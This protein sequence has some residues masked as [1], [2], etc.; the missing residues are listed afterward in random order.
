M[1]ISCFP[2]IIKQVQTDYPIAMDGYLRRSQEELHHL[3]ASSRPQCSWAHPMRYIGN[4]NL[5]YRQLCSLSLS[6]EWKSK[7]IHH[8]LYI[9]RITLSAPK[10]KKETHTQWHKDDPIVKESEWAIIVRMSWWHAIAVFGSPTIFW[11]KFWTCDSLV[12]STFL[13]HAQKHTHTNIYR[14]TNIRVW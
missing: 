11:T 3:C 1:V 5:K 2:N 14:Q 9:Y 6:M 13:G 7:N 8:T 12:S 4:N 10:N